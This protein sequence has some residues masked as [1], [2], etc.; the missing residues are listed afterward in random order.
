M[1]VA[2]CQPLMLNGGDSAIDNVS[3]R[4]IVNVHHPM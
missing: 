1:P 2:A 3:K 4:Q